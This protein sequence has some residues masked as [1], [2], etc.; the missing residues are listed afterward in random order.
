MEYFEEDVLGLSGI[1]CGKQTWNIRS[2]GAWLPGKC[3]LCNNQSRKNGDIPS[4][5]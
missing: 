5:K 2:Y 4:P 3:N 1:V